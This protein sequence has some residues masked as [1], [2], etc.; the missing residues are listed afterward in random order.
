MLTVRRE[1]EGPRTPRRASVSTTSASFA[2]CAGI[3]PQHPPTMPTPSCSMYFSIAAAKGSGAS[4]YS[5]RPSTSTGSPALGMT[6][7]RRPGD[8]APQW[9]PSQWTCS[10]I[11]VGPVAQFMPSEMMG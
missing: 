8:A 4:G 7:T 6:D 10:A 5:V 9:R 11:S 1:V 3:V 2:M